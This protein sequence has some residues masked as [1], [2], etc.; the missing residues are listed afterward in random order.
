MEITTK[1]K[2]LSMN[3]AMKDPFIRI[4]KSHSLLPKNF[5]IKTKTKTHKNSN[6]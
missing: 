6:L 5:M 4:A 1:M 3:K 2:K